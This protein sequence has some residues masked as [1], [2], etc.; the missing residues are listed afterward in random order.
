MLVRDWMTREP[1]VVSPK[2]SV[3]E[4]IRIM[5]NNRV[6]H[7]PVVKDKDTL[8][9]IVTQT[10]LLQASP[11]PATSLSVWEINFLL[12]K[13]QV[14]DA[15]TE[16][17]VVVEEECPLEEAA[18]VMAQHKIGCLPVVHGH[19]LV[20]IITETDLF[21][22]FTEQ[23]G[24]RSTGV[25]LTL[26]IE[27]VK[28][29]LARLTGRIAELGGN[30]VRLTTLPGKTADHQIVTVKV[31]DVAQEALVTGLSA[32]VIEVLDAR[33]GRGWGTEGFSPYHWTLEG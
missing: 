27:D 33:E 13:M 17:V 11:S 16:K 26:L 31:E 5:R 1:L 15:M 10:D 25:R 14:R 8:V 28:G 19:R 29:E 3:E 6:R 30:I 2:T 12:A 22:L 23:L 7:L 20:G 18:L 9:G 4:A 24:A 32:Q 21:N